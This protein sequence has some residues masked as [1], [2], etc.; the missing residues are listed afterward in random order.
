MMSQESP[1]LTLT[2]FHDARHCPHE[3]GDGIKVTAM[4]SEVQPNFSDSKTRFFP[5]LS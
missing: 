4:E 2:G 1:H 3:G 5:L